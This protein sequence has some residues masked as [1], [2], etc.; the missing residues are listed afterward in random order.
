VLLFSPRVALPFWLFSS[1]AVSLAIVLGLLLGA[2]LD[3][4]CATAF[5]CERSSVASRERR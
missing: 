5:Q 1:I 4:G 3:V 2:A